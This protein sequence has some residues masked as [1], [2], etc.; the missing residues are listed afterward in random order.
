MGGILPTEAGALIEALKARRPRFVFLSACLTAAASERR[1]AWRGDKQ[2]ED[3]PQ[4]SVAVAQSLAEALVDGG[5]PA[6][7]GRGGNYRIYGLEHLGRLSFIRRA[8]DLG[9]SI[10]QVRELLSLTDQQS[11]SC[12][13]VDAIA[14]QHLAEVERKIA[15]LNGMRRELSTVIDQC[16]RNVIADCRII[17]AL[18]PT[19]K[20]VEARKKPEGWSRRCRVQRRARTPDG[21]STL[22]ATF[23]FQCRADRFVH[24]LGRCGR[25]IGPS[26]AVR[27]SMSVLI[28]HPCECGRGMRRLIGHVQ[29]PAGTIAA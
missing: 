27:C 15:D 26:F 16:G 4:G 21:N 18:S 8:R 3:K 5:I 28:F 2:A 29:S 6:V 19:G 25:G 14:R 23:L 22:Q 1:D 10:E 12:A 17:E 11:R 7:L 9:F 13:R 24:C 20:R